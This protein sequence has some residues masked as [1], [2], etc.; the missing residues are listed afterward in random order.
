[1]SRFR[2]I[3]R[4]SIQADAGAHRVSDTTDKAA[5]APGADGVAVRHLQVVPA[6]PHRPATSDHPYPVTPARPHSAGCPADITSEPDTPTPDA[7]AQP[8]RRRSPLLVT[9]ARLTERGVVTLAAAAP[10]A[11]WLTAGRPWLP[12]IAAVAA[13]VLVAAARWALP[14]PLRRPLTAGVGVG[15]AALFVTAPL[16]P[17]LLVGG[18]AAVIVLLINR[19]GT[20]RRPGFE[21]RPSRPTA[22]L[23]ALLLAAGL[24]IAGLAGLVVQH[25]AAK[26]QHTEQVQQAAQGPAEPLPPTPEQAARA[27]LQAIADGDP[28]V[29]TLLLAA[30]A[31][32]Q[33]TTLT[34]S[35]DCPTTVHALAGRV[36]DPAHY[37]APNSDALPVTRDAATR[38]VTID[39]CHLTWPRADQVHSTDPGGPPGPQ[40]G[41]LDLVPVLGQGYQITSIHPCTT[42]ARTPTDDQTSPGPVATSPPADTRGARDSGH[43]I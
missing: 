20:D 17:R 1:M 42:S 11:L 40:I 12:V 3:P 19:P 16:W 22:W 6:A 21:A 28:N 36:T 8:S 39:A 43:W 15:S 14:R 41:R 2:L 30:P 25:I 4:A 23:L 32:A 13:T 27:L 18:A 5:D 7:V 24:A 10:V 9:G 29:C 34:G 33:L 37:P 26:H 31:A 35:P 38:S